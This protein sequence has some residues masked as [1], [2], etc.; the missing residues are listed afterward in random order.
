VD[1]S[2]VIN[3]G[4]LLLTAVGLGF[5]AWMALDARGARDDAQTARDKAKVH[6]EAALEAARQSAESSTRAANALERSA[7]AAEAAIEKPDISIERLSKT[8]W[9]I[10]NESGFVL[11]FVEF[12]T[13]PPD[14][15][16]VESGPNQT[17][18]P[19]EGTFI[20]FGGGVSDPSHVTV[21]MS[22]RHPRN[23][24]QSSLFTL[25]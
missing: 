14:V 22:Y 5:T 2:N 21:D 20:Q 7:A 8:R 24:G 25:P 23:G 10:T 15:L 3:L 18:A 9:K 4:L 6:E 1:I 19:G 12:T 17:L 16:T 13:Q 11:D